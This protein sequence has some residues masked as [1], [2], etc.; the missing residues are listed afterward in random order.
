M[1][2]TSDTDDQANGHGRTHVGWEGNA[3]VNGL[4]NNHVDGESNG[5]GTFYAEGGIYQSLQHVQYYATILP[6]AALAS[7]NSEAEM[8]ELAEIRFNLQSCL[9]RVP[10]LLGELEGQAE[11]AFDS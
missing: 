10:T 3:H 7:T 11:I 9:R 1:S 6:Q 8:A 5:D 4:G 2:S